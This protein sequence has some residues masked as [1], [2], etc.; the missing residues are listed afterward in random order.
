V[1]LTDWATRS[2]THSIPVVRG[3]FGEAGE[4]AEFD[5]TGFSIPPSEAI[6]NATF[7]VQLTSLQV[8]GLGVNVGENP[9][10]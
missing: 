8:G 5:I 10:F 9:Q 6:T 1:H 7:Q 3:T 2:S 4:F